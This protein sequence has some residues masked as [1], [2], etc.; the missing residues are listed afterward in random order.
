VGVVLLGLVAFGLFAAF[1]EAARDGSGGARVA[2]IIEGGVLLAFAGLGV[3]VAY[4]FIA[5]KCDENCDESLVPAARSGDWWHTQ[6]AWQWWAQM[7]VALGGFI[8]GAA[9]LSC[10]VRRQYRRGT[11]WLLVAAACF[12]VWAGFVAP[13]GNALGI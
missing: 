7:F 1:A 3:L 8:A 9:A 12:G 13:L 5:L 6:D 4:A 11:G 2:V 10:V